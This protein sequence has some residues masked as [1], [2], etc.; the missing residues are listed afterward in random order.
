MVHQGQRIGGV[1]VEQEGHDEPGAEDPQGDVLRDEGHEQ[2]P[3]GVGIHVYVRDPVDIGEEDLP[4]AHHVGEDEADDDDAGQ[5]HHPFLAYSGS[6]EADRPG[7]PS[8]LDRRCHRASHYGNSKRL[9]G[10]KGRGTGFSNRDKAEFD[11]RG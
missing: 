11:A 9:S 4:V 3:E 6:V 5:R 10:C 8:P 1:D 7:G 2:L